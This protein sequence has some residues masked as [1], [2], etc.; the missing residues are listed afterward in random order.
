MPRVKTS[1]IT[2]KYTN[3]SCSPIYVIGVHDLQ[4]LHEIGIA[5]KWMR[6]ICRLVVLPF[7]TRLQSSFV[8]N[9]FHAFMVD[10]PSLS[11]QLVRDAPIAI[12]QPL[13]SFCFDGL[14]QRLFICN[15]CSMKVAASGV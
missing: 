5:R 8:H 14:P 4:M 1:I 2:A 12:G 13:G 7:P 11:P 6:T 3:S 9:P 10:R 15:P